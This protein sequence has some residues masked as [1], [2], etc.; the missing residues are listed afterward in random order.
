MPRMLSFRL[1]SLPLLLGLALA[2]FMQ[3]LACT[4]DDPLRVEL[5]VH[6]DRGEGFDRGQ[7]VAVHASGCVALERPAFHRQPGAAISHMAASELGGLETQLRAPALRGLDPA[8]VL[9]RAKSVGNTRRYVSHPTWYRL[10]IHE[11]G[12]VREIRAESVLQHVELD[13]GLSELQP[14]AA[15]IRNLLELD[16]RAAAASGDTG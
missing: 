14:L 8:A 15:L 5:R 1:C 6:S 7:R 3:A 16:A 13:P 9:Q 2:P 12:G 10:R 4:A 11:P